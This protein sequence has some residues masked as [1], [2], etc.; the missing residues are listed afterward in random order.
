MIEIKN[1]FEL[2][3]VVEFLNKRDLVK[4]YKKSKYYIFDRQ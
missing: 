1:I 4:Q 3:V 2:E